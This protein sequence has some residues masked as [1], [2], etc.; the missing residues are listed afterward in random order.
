[1]NLSRTFLWRKLRER[2][3]LKAHRRAAGI[4]EK[5]I[6]DY[7][8]NPVHF[9][10]APK[11]HFDSDRIIW[12]YWAQGYDDVPPVVRECLESVEKYAGGYT[13]VRLTDENLQDYLDLPDFVQLKRQSVFSRAFFS[14][15]LRLML[16]KTYGG[17]WMDA[18]IMLS[19]P[20][21]EE[22][23]DNDLFFFRRDPNEPHIPYWRN[24]YAYYF[25]W[26]K[27][28]RV[29]MLSSFMVGK[30]DSRSISELCDL[31][32]LWWKDH[33]NLP[34]YFFLQILLDVY[35]CQESFPLVSDTLP[36]YLQQSINDPAFKLMSREKI[37]HSIPIH[38]LTYK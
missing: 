11:R 26:A 24:T 23:A 30:K 6:A 31:M 34:D 3:I 22:Y 27:G 29:N 10:L 14:D 16:L 37:L 18:T 38:K 36:H 13:L 1:M 32:L 4:C 7:R 2:K 25:G 28:F 35:G 12:Q 21:P 5:L 8:K 9:A 15:L 19:G 17:I 33:D 20:I